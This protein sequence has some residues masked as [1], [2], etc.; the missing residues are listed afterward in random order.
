MSSSTREGGGRATDLERHLP[1]ISPDP[2]QTPSLL[3]FLA[4]SLH[5][6]LYA[7]IIIFSVM[8]SMRPS[9]P[10]RAKRLPRTLC[11]SPSAF[12]SPLV[13]CPPD[14]C[15]S[16]H[17]SAHGQQRLLNSWSAVPLDDPIVFSE[18]PSAITVTALH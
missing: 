6:S 4:C 2:I 17:T 15:P 16:Y 10:R 18:T 13:V 1:F 7:S 8:Q 5:V 9:P 14:L 3:P 11:A 12:L